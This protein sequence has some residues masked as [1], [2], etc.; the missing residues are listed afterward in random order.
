MVKIN[1]YYTSPK[2]DL[3]GN[4]DEFIDLFESFCS[5]VAAGDSA[6]VYT[7]LSS[8]PEPLKFDMYHMDQTNLC[9]C[10]YEQLKLKRK[11]SPVSHRQ[12]INQ[13]RNY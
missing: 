6:K 13:D 4:S 7:F 10:T 1:F 9:T 2:F 3:G 11:L 8:L 5:R 12:E